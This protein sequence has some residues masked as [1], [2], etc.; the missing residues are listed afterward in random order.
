[1]KVRPLS[2]ACSIG[3][4]PSGDGNYRDAVEFARLLFQCRENED[5]A[6]RFFNSFGVT[7]DVVYKS[8]MDEVQRL[9][10]KFKKRK[11]RFHNRQSGEFSI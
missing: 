10:H 2:T 3:V 6:L 7:P 4:L 8:V 5:F 9:G 1:M 11:K